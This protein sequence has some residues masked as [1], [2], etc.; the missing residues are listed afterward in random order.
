MGS[1]VRVRVGYAFSKNI[2][3]ENGW[4]SAAGTYSADGQTH[5]GSGTLGGFVGEW[6]QIEIPYGI[7]CKRFEIYPRTYDYPNPQLP[8]DFVILGSND[9]VNYD[10]LKSVTNNTNTAKRRWMSFPITTNKSYKYFA[11]V[12][13]KST[14][15]SVTAFAELRYFG[16]REQGQSVLHDG[17]LTLTKS[18]TVPRI[19]PALDADDTPRRDRLVVEYNTSTNPTFEGAVRDTSGRGNDG[20]F[21]GNTYYDATTKALDFDGLGNDYVERQLN[22]SGDFD[23]TVSLW[24]KRNSDSA[25]MDVWFLGGTLTQTRVMVP[26]FNWKVKVSDIFI[27]LVGVY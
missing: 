4:A 17:E 16:T 22:N 5:T 21:Y 6:V 8:K 1:F 26:V 7:V 9:G 11:I 10:S 14:S 12:I 3:D 23:F 20:V 24:I 27:F 19:G 25:T 2:G 13:S 15:T 18:L